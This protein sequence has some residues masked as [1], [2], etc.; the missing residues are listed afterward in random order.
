MQ[1]FLDNTPLAV[2]RPTIAAALRAGCRAAEAAHRIVIEATIN[3]API[4]GEH[5]LNPPEDAHP[6]AEIRL[7]TADPRELVAGTLDEVATAMPLAESEQGAATEAIHQGRV[8]QS[9]AHLA[10][11]LGVW[12]QARQ[13]VDHSARLLQ[14]PLEELDCGPDG[15]ARMTISARTTVL[16]ASLTE[17]KSAIQARDWAGLADVLAYDLG[18][19]AAAWGRVLTDLSARV[20][21]SGA[22]G[23]G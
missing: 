3:G 23:R 10:S 5:L 12:D 15:D 14:L 21:S 13:V 17:V 16:A 18:P 11:A 2:D 22:D 7:T 8:D 4:P 9:L 19:Q 1:V 6:G 20:R